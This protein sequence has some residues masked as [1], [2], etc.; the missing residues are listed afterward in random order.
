MATER[1]TF[2]F[3]AT[4]EFTIEKHKTYFTTLSMFLISLELPNKERHGTVLKW[5]CSPYTEHTWPI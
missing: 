5:I 2:G 1:E 3:N 4:T